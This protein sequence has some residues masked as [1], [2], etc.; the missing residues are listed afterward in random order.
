MLN[1]KNVLNSSGTV[2]PVPP[3]ARSSGTVP[4]VPPPAH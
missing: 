1:A 4:P 3:P 2:P